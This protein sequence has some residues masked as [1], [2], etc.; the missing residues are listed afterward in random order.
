MP[1]FTYR[2]QCAFDFRR[3]TTAHL[4]EHMGTRQ[5]GRQVQH[6]A[7]W[8]AVAV[9]QAGVM[10]FEQRR[11]TQFGGHV[12]EYASRQVEIT[13]EHAINHAFAAGL[14]DLQVD[15]RRFMA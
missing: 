12:G 10:L 5:V 15:A 4:Q 11:S 6:A 9:D 14:D 3:A 2:A 1:S 13:I 7:G 8:K